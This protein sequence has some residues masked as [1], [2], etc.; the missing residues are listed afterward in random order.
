MKKVPEIFFDDLRHEILP[1]IE[2]TVNDVISSYEV[3]TVAYTNY[4]VGCNAHDNSKTRFEIVGGRSNIFSTNTKKSVAWVTWKREGYDKIVFFIPRVGPQTRI[5]KNSKGVKRKLLSDQHILSPEIFSRALAIGVYSLGY[6]FDQFNGLGKI[7]FD[8]LAAFSKNKIYAETI[9]TLR[10][11]AIGIS[12]Q[13]TVAEKLP[14]GKAQRK[15]DVASL[16]K[17]KARAS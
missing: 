17:K 1:E 10:T 12:E 13:K 16:Q 8:R 11:S 3:N 6:D 5:P 9:E 7:T 2:E 4:S 14:T 15:A